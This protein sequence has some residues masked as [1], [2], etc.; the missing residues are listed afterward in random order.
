MEKM[1]EFTGKKP[2]YRQC[3]SA[4]QKLAKAGATVINLHWGENWLELRKQTNATW[5][6]F[7]F[8]RDIDASTI[9]QTL[10]QETA[11]QFMRDH[12]ALVHVR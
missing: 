10:N 6:G 7:G 4:A 8:I 3:L 5:C 12:F 1:H 9:A 11:R 2:S